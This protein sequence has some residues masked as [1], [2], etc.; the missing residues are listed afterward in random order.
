ME[1]DQSVS[2]I[3]DQSSSLFVE[4]ALSSSLNYGSVSQIELKA[5]SGEDILVIHL[6][7]HFC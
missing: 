1:G 4:P 7:Y 2:L 6:V 5:L 3:D